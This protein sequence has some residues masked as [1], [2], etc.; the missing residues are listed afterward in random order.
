MALSIDE[1]RQKLEEDRLAGKH[2]LPKG[3]TAADREDEA[4]GEEIASTPLELGAHASLV[5]TK[6]YRR[7]VKC[8]RF[9]FVTFPAAGK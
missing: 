6:C 8:R 7:H 4:W 2:G 5:L 3:E 1:F 9:P